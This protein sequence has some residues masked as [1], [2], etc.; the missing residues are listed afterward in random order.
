[1][2]RGPAPVGQKEPDEVFQDLIQVPPG[3][4]PNEGLAG[5]STWRSATERTI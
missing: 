2:S 1:M 4:Q 5:R 3:Q